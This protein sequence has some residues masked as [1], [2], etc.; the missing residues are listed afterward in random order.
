M[1]GYTVKYTACQRY[2]HITQQD[3]RVYGRNYNANSSVSSTRRL[4]PLIPK[5]S[6]TKPRVSWRNLGGSASSNTRFNGSNNAEGGKSQPG[7]RSERSDQTT[8][9]P[10]RWK[11]R[12]EGR[13]TQPNGTP[14]VKAGQWGSKDLR[15]IYM[16]TPRRKISHYDP[17]HLSPHVIRCT[18]CYYRTPELI[19]ITA[20]SPHDS[21]E[22]S[23]KD[24]DPLFSLYLRSQSPSCSSL[25]DKDDRHSNVNHE[26]GIH[27]HTVAPRETELPN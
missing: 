16:P 11:A 23:L 22:S 3:E 10:L 27:L 19:H 17:H 12:K 26:G 9:E 18:Y 21:Y 5:S 6:K 14:P 15:A 20:T 25:A 13:R 7:A 2:Q 8:T 1:N 24:N 4:V